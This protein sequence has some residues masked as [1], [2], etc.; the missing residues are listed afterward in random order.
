MALFVVHGSKLR[1]MEPDWLHSF[2][3][4]INGE[5]F[6]KTPPPTSS[7][8]LYSHPDILKSFCRF[9]C[10]WEVS[11]IHCHSWKTVYLNFDE[12]AVIK[13]PH[14]WLDYKAVQ[15]NLSKKKK[16]VTLSKNLILTGTVRATPQQTKTT[17]KR[18]RPR[19]AVCS[20]TLSHKLLLKFMTLSRIISQSE[21][22]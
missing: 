11:F 1:Y 12:W 4:C 14:A 13:G 21:N 17:R 16:A 15:F 9:S 8:M 22:Y 10:N 19:R 2:S 6:V 7:F 5:C 3:R 20:S 18:N